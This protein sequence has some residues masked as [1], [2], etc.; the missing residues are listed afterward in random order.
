[1]ADTPGGGPYGPDEMFRRLSIRRTAATSDE[2]GRGKSDVATEMRANRRVNQ[3]LAS[4]A[5]RTG[6]GGA[7]ISFATGR[8]RDPLFYWQQNNMPFDIYNPEQLKALRAVCR[9]VY[10]THPLLSSCIDIY[11]KYPL[12]G[13]E[14]TCKDTALTEFYTDHFFGDLNFEEYLPDCGRE[15]WTV[16][17]AWPFGSFNEML[18]VWED[19]ELLNADDIKV[20]RSP[21][22]REPRYEMRLPESI[23]LILEKRE[24]KWEYERLIREYPEFAVMREDETMPVSNILL[25][26]LRFKAHSFHPRGLPILLRAFRAIMQE[27]MLNTAQDAIADRLYTPLILAKLGA[28]AAD[29]GTTVPWVPDEGDLADFEDALDAA[30]AADFRVLVHHFAVDMQNVFGRENMPN[31]SMDFERIGDSQLQVFGLS[32]TMLQGASSGQTYAA[33]ALNRDLVTQLLSGYQKVLTR[34][35]KERAMVVAEAQEH[36]DFETRAGTRYPIM[37]EVLEVDEE[38][39]ERRIVEQPKL[40]VPDL[41]IRAMNLQ[42]DEVFRQFVEQLAEA[43]V[44][45]SIKTRLVN[46]PIDLEEER[47][48]VATERIDLAVWDAETR[49]ATYLALRNRGLTVPPELL[50][51]FQPMASDVGAAAET[52]GALDELAGAEMETQQ[53]VDEAS[54]LSAADGEHGNER[55][56]GSDKGGSVIEL[57]RNR[58]K[59]RPQ[60]S[61]EQRKKMPKPAVLA[62]RTDEERDIAVESMTDEQ[63]TTLREELER[64][65]HKG[66]ISGG[67]EHIGMRR[68]S[69]INKDTPLDDDE[70]STG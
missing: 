9:L 41:K 66:G 19:D 61:D 4:A 65:V 26:Q 64:G 70:R 49:K 69:S 28:S 34:F 56:T 58:I 33:D 45:I 1:M 12:T 35:Y 55:G 6:G 5:E 59:D 15:Y 8:P 62:A 44:P 67:P 16:G 10:L 50:A 38:T 25:K 60:E 40:L 42:D 51:E 32:R 43:G 68:H 21:F 48:A 54:A 29:L 31:L 47:E 22:L 39:G 53:A 27:E 24:P 2:D 13:M 3:R 57:P 52:Q 36:W 7:N 18:G 14:L 17:E 30:L 46:V 11:S 63:R 20:V 37:E 23:R